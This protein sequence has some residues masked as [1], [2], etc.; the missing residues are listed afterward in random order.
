MEKN[1]VQLPRHTLMLDGR[2]RAQ[3]DG[4][5]GGELLQR[6]GGCAGNRRGRGGAARRKPAHRAAEPRRRPARRDRRDRGRRIQRGDPEKGAARAV[7]PQEGVTAAQQAQA[8]GWMAALG[9]AAGLCY[10]LLGRL[11]RGRLTAGAADLFLGRSAR[12]A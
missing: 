9:A 5:D 8:L 1:T 12:R 3:A 2:A 7:R 10:D 11:R 6:P 4:R